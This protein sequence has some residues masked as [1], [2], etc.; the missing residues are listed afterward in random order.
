MP[1]TSIIPQRDRVPLPPESDL[2]VV[3]LMATAEDVVEEEVVL[4]LGHIEKSLGEASIHVQRLP[5]SHRVYRT[6]KLPLHFLVTT[7]STWQ[8]CGGLDSLVRTTG[9]IAV[10]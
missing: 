5:A 1:G 4:I 9:C 6:C 7:R 8:H 2:R 3:V 10:K